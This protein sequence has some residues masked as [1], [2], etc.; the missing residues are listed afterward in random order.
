MVPGLPDDTSRWRCGHCGNLTRFDVTRS[1]TTTEYWHFS[2]AGKPH[3]EETQV[4]AETVEKVL[5]RWCGATDRIELVPRPD[6]S[7]PGG[8]GPEPALGGTP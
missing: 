7:D 8:A 1:R 3:V 2:L 4:G 6:P 5:C